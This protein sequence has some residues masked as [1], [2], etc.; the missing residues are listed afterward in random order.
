VEQVHGP[1][2]VSKTGTLLS[3]SFWLL[4]ILTQENVSEMAGLAAFFAG[5]VTG[6]YTIW[7]W[8]N[9]WLRKKHYTHKK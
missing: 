4:H 8:R 1:D 6:L 2:G 9:E 5:I 7:K 3:A